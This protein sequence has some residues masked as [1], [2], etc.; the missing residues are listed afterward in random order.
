M[1]VSTPYFGS[2][3]RT[4]SFEC[5]ACHWSGKT[6]EMSSEPFRE[7]MEYSCPQCFEILVLVSYPTRQEVEGAAAAGDAEGIVELRRIR[8]SGR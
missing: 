8:E 2:D 6:D 4:R 3:W 5:L 7:L 1:S